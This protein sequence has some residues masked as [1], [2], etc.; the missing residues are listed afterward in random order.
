[1]RLQV[2]YRDRKGHTRRINF[3]V[4]KP[5]F[6]KH[7]GI[8]GMGYAPRLHK[9]RRVIGMFLHYG[10]Y[11]RDFS[12]NKFS[13]PLIQDPTEKG[14]F[15]NLVGKAIADYL[16]KR[17]NRAFFTVNYEFA[18]RERR[19]PLRGYRPDLIAFGKNF[20]FAIE[21]KGFSKS[22]VSNIEMNGYKLQA[23]SGPIPVNFAVASVSYNLY[24]S[25]KC[26]YYDP[27][28]DYRFDE[29]DEGL[30]KKIS[31]QYYSGLKEFLNEKYFEIQTEIYRNEEF[32]VL[33]PRYK[34]L[35]SWGTL[36]CI[37]K[38]WFIKWSLILTKKIDKFAKEGITGAL[39]PFEMFEEENVYIDA[40]RIGIK[41]LYKLK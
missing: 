25:V 19:I 23:C 27:F 12:K 36:R 22:Y 17:I 16:S 8:A 21:A 30:L 4:T 38:C 37:W 13:E 5:A 34:T 1:M 41:L 32:Y 9:F 31:R 24:N 7:M 33:T 10:D 28:I 35:I 29:K 15:S 18:M 11:F 20:R 14:Q 6:I 40:D 3:N 2:I 26:K 39:A